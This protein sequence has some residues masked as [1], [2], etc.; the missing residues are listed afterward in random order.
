MMVRMRKIIRDT[1]HRRSQPPSPFLPRPRWAGW[2]VLIMAGYVVGEFAEPVLP[3][4]HL[5]TPLLAGLALAAI[6]PTPDRVPARLNRTCQAA[7]GVL[8][9]S[10][11]NPQ[12]QQHA[13]TAVLPLTAV[14]AATI[15]LSLVA[16]AVMA[17]IGRI[18]RASA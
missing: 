8:I 16:A 6:G 12:T 14:T 1:R 10:Y 13:S 11:L 5:L 7:L 2:L 4:A 17:R 18:G 3:A 15:G 9:G